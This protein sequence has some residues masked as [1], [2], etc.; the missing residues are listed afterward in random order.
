VI[1]GGTA[2]VSVVSQLSR[3]P[4]IFYHN[5]RVF[6]AKKMHYYQPGFTVIG[7]LDEKSLVQKRTK[8]MF[9]S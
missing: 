3:E 5:I 2:G 6:E 8:D 9:N 1:G 7:G 4:E